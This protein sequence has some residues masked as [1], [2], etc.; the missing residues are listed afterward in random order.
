MEQRA[1]A[2]VAFLHCVRKEILLG[3][4]RRNARV[5]KRL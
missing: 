5:L 3:M 4:I 2:C 1:L